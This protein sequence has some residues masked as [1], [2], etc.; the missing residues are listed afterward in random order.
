[1]TEHKPFVFK[2]E[3]IEVRENEY[4]LTRSGET[5]KIEPTAFRVLL[6]LLRNPGR[7]VSKDEIMAAVWHDTA[8]SDNSLT[9]SVATLRRVL[10]DSSREP[11]YIATVQTLGYRFLVPVEKLLVGSVPESAVDPDPS[12]ENGS[13][14]AP[15]PVAPAPVPPLRPSLSRWKIVAGAVIL[16][17]LVLAGFHFFGDGRSRANAG[18]IY[19][20]FVKVPKPVVTVPGLVWYPAL[21]PDGR[22]IAFTW[23]SESQPQGNLYVQLIGGDQPL[24][25]T[26]NTSGSICCAAWS[27]DGQQIAYERCDDHG[28]VVFI[29]PALGGMERKITEVVCMFGQGGWPQWTAGGDSLVLADRC[30]PTGPRGVVLFS[31]RTGERQCLASPPPGVDEGDTWPSLSPDQK[32]VAFFRSADGEHEEVY[33][34]DIA[35]KKVRQLTHGGYGDTGPLVWTVDGKYVMFKSAAPDI[36]GPVR[37]SVD[38]GALEAASTL[39]ATGSLSRDGRRLAYIEGTKS[40]SIWR[41]DLASAGGKVR[42]IRSIGLSSLREDSPQLAPDGHDI[43]VRSSRAAGI[44]QL[45][46]TDIDGQAPVQLTGTTGPVGSPDW[47]PDGKWIA[48]DVRPADHTQIWMIDSEGRNFHAVIADQYENFVPRWSRDGR[49]IYFTSNRSGEWQIWKLDLASGQKTRITDQGGLSPIESY[50]GS[51]L[52]Y[53]KRESGG[54]FRRPLSGGPEV[55][56][57]DGLHVRYWGAFAVTENGIYFLDTEATPRPT[58]FYL[59]LR[60]GRSI[61]VL[62]MERM[63][64]P[65]DPTLTATRDGRILFFAELDAVTHINLAEASP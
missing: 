64:A 53:S 4:A 34:V 45:W 25:L 51:M 54:I 46:K 7:L 11:R 29:V 24:Q 39:P 21:S 50:D 37:V 12:P 42:S 62:P 65:D 20:S 57:T 35:G 26:H 56:V 58:I 16:A 38:G 40:A 19:P 15:V 63:P 17:A 32:S 48:M 28:G 23:R 10:D 49:S 8:V 31:L 30:T 5:V 59:D 61:P 9:R 43:V 55:R 14:A 47:S 60:T 13:Q 41:V 3:D 1:V 36:R 18:S 27:P 22:Q 52:Y 2:F 44:A 33:T 6:F